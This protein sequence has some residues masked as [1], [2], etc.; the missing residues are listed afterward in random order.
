LLLQLR[1]EHPFITQWLRQQLPHGGSR[2]EG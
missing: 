1:L 2:R